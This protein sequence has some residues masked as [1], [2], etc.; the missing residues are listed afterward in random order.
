[1]RA[2]SGG[3]GV[4]QDPPP[5]WG[6][7]RTN[8]QGDNLGHLVR[9]QGKDGTP[10]GLETGGRCFEKEERFPA[11]AHFAVPPEERGKAGHDVGAGRQAAGHEVARHTSGDGARRAGHEDD[12]HCLTRSAHTSFGFGFRV[13]G[14]YRLRATQSS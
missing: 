4:G 14:S 12:D 10:Q 6:M 2:L 1:M 7:R 13:D 5:V 9:V 3:T 8:R 11:L